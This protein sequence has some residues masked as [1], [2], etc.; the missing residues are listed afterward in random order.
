MDLSKRTGLAAMPKMP[1]SCHNRL[2]RRSRQHPHR[3]GLDLTTPLGR[4]V[5]ALHSGMAEEQRIRIQRHANEGRCAPSSAANASSTITSR[6]KLSCAWPLAKA[7]E[8]LPRRWPC[9]TPR[10]RGRRARS[11]QRARRRVAIRRTLYQSWRASEPSSGS[12]IS[13]VTP[14]GERW[15]S[16]MPPNSNVRSLRIRSVP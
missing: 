6:P 2:V 14:L 15:C 3:P 11:R 10:S 12:E 9:T 1:A 16:T 13:H 4:G 8:R 7:A 5:L